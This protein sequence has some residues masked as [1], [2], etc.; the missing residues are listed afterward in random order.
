MRRFS[1]YSHAAKAPKPIRN[2]NRRIRM[3]MLFMVMASD[4]A[5]KGCN[6]VIV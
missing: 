3:T 4:V 2:E 1:I 6:Q 5:D